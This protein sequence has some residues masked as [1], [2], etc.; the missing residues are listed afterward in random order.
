MKFFGAFLFSILALAAT[1]QTWVQ[2]ANFPGSER[3][4]GA[5]FSIGY[6]AY[7]GTG[8]TAWFAPTADFYALDLTTDIWSP[9]AAMPATTERQYACGFA[10]NT[11][12]YIFGGL[13]GNTLLNDLWQYDPAQD[14]WIQKTSLPAAG[15]SGSA[16]FVIN[17]TAYI[18]GGRTAANNA[19]AE[20][21]AYNILTDSW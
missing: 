21:W 16:C 18:I 10:S 9:I 19:I 7:C 2:L 4:D 12:G 5:C 3:D 17:D 14:A 6:K 1:A 15:R 11:H 13:N 8:L 20:V